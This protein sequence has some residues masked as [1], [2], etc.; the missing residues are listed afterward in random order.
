MAT[1]TDVSSMAGSKIPAVDTR[2]S[3]H[4]SGD[5]AGAPHVPELAVEERA[6]EWTALLGTVHDAVMAVD[7]EGRVKSWYQGA[8]RLFGWTSAEAVGQEL[9]TLILGGSR[10]PWLQLRQDVLEEGDWEGELQPYT[11]NRQPLVVEGRANLFRDAQDRPKAI[12]LAAA[13]VTERRQLQKQV[14]RG[15]RL[16]SLGT[17]AC[18]IA[19]DLN[20]VLTPVQM[21]ADLLRSS[22][23]GPDGARF[24]DLLS[25]STR[26]GTEI[27][28]QLLLFGRGVEG[29]RGRMDLRYLV[30]ETATILGE[31]FPK[32]I[33]V[34]TRID[35][36]VW[37]VLGDATQLH[38]VLL[39][40]CVN[41]RDAMPRGG[42]LTLSLSNLDLDLSAIQPPSEAR[43]GRYVVVAIADTGTGIPP[44]ILNRIFDPFFTTKTHIGG[45]G[46][47][48]ST[49]QS[50]VR[51]HGGFLEVTTHLGAG[52]AFRVHLPAD[53]DAAAEALP[54]V[55]TFTPPG[56]KQW[57]LVVDDEDA[58]RE[59]VRTSLERVGYRVLTAG[60]GAEAVS[61]FGRR[62]AEIAAVVMDM[63]L[64]FLD[65]ATAIAMFRRFR[66]SIPIIAISGLPSQKEEAERASG[67][68]IRYLQKPFQMKELV[69]ELNRSLHG[70]AETSDPVPNSDKP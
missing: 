42:V 60:D 45:T 11:R 28:R 25:R 64:P 30:K 9:S 57:I 7:M 66:P 24:L 32:S 67:G 40:L 53:A 8:E 10:A 33:Q 14:F 54:A 61:L 4:G 47:G 15:Q 38:Q 2:P 5:L 35:E 52:S 13:D 20:N 68:T 39:N 31:T 41:A 36:K 18:G 17:L 6:R 59:L 27:I 12:L 3:L 21:V 43:P 63:V 19:H 65:G 23:V 55:S 51:S 34:H 37:Q 70:A 48:L 44:E 58:I 22:V 1:S 56:E 50:I 62:Q 29:T 26:R 16:E 49:A 69:Q 46:L